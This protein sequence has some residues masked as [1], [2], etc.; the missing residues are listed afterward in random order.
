[1][2]TEVHMDEV[3]KITDI[4]MT[5]TTLTMVVKAIMVL[6]VRSVADMKTMVLIAITTN[7]VGM[8]KIC[9]AVTPA[10]IAT[11]ILEIVTKVTVIMKAAV[12]VQAVI[13]DATI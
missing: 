8:Q 4:K 13:T 11:D 9:I 3:T 12:E 7:G 10:S 2:K 1:M 5:G 6:E